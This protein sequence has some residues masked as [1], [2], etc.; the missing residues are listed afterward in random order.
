MLV[1]LFSG[2]GL[3]LAGIGL[4]GIIAFAVTQRTREIGIRM[5]VGASAPAVLALVLRQGLGLAIAGL[6]AGLI[7]GAAAT[8]IIAGALSGVGVADPVAWGTAAGVLFSAAIL[9]NAIPA[10][11]AVRIDPVRA[12]QAGR[13]IADS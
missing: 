9:A 6:V 1:S 4:Y 10:W 5:A 2:L 3:L 13:L 7:L 12:P 11:R 8:R